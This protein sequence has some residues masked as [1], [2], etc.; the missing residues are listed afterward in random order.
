M[1]VFG[2]IHIIEDESEKLAALRSLGERY[3]PNDNA[4]LQREIDKGF[5]HLHILRLDIEHI[6]G[7]ESIE[8]IKAN[9][10]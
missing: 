4:G 1:I 3:N 10:Q 6:S 7:K 5:S 2:R 8:L 9:R